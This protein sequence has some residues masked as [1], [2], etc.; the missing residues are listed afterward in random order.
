MSCDTPQPLS[1]GALVPQRRQCLLD[2]FDLAEPPVGACAYAAL[3][4]IGS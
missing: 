3:L 2:P 4:Q 1:A